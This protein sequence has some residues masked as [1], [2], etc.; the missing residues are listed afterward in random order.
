MRIHNHTWILL[1]F[2]VSI[3]TFLALNTTSRADETSNSV[4]KI[5]VTQRGPDYSRPWTKSAPTSSV[6]SGSIIEGNRILTNAHVVRFATQILVQANQSSDR[7]RAKLLAIAPSLDL[8][9]LEVQDEA[10][11]EG[12]KPLEF[13]AAIPHVKDTLNVYGYP[14]GGEQLSITEGIVSRIEYTKSSETE[15]I[16]MLQVDAALNPG[17]SGGPAI[18]NGKIVGV[19]CSKIEQADNIGYLI[20]TEEVLR[21]LDDVKDGSY[22]GKPYIPHTGV[23]QYTENQE[24]RKRLKLP[25]GTGGILINESPRQ[26]PEL[27]LQPWDVI[28]HIGDHPLDKQGMVSLR[29]DLKLEYT[30]FI[31]KLVKDGKVPLTIMRDGKSIKIEAP[32]TTKGLLVL[33]PLGNNYPRYY[34]HGPLVVME[35]DSSLAELLLKGMGPALLNARSPWMLRLGDTKKFPDEE[36]V[37]LGL[38]FYP[39]PISQGYEKIP[40]FSIISHINDTEVKNLRHAVKLLKHAEGEFLTIRLA[41]Y[42][43]QI[44]FPREEAAELT[45][46]ILESEGIRNQCSPDLRDVE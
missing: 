20:A 43:S 5:H 37:M 34:I 30:Y 44:V 42:N 15:S 31:P 26:D 46:D 6:G 33:Q 10:F 36:L 3:V 22:E 17:N 25:E 19:V 32:T 35:A 41:G 16:L 12:R 8:A 14:M 45:E 2:A 1:T 38:R 11:A 9:L 21:F 23:Q 29:D 7:Y 39:H 28:T 27:P 18:I 40:P 4:V 13:D 24:L